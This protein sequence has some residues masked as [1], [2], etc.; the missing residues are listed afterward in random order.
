VI[1]DLTWRIPAGTTAALVGPTGVG[2]TTLLSLLPRLYDPWQGCVR[3]GGVDTAQVSLQELRAS[4]TLVLQESLLFRDTVWNNV[5]YGRPDASSEEILAA[6][7]T[8]GVGTFVDQLE[9]GYQTVVSERGATLS[10]GQKQCVAIA[11]ALLRDAPVVIMDE[12]TSSLDSVTEHLVI[13]GLDRLVS[14]RTAIII[15]HRFSTIQSATRVAVMEGGRIVQEGPPSELLAQPG[16]YARLSS[17]QGFDADKLRIR[18]DQPL[19]R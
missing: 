9:D 12:P 2:K 7:V 8:A 15:A 4:V 14:D 3:L 1:E 16:L 10:G 11:R 6:A 17:Y 13:Q 19:A 18:A 5:A